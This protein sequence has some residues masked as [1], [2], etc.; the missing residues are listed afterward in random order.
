MNEV[1]FVI[2][3]SLR[4]LPLRRKQFIDLG[5]RNYFAITQ[6]SRTQCI[7]GDKDEFTVVWSMAPCSL[8]GEYRRC[9][10]N[11]IP[12]YSEL[13]PDHTLSLHRTLQ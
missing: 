8:V 2:S 12:A 1:G 11:T 10:R 6:V 5:A 7:H 13:E 3:V 9:W 4:F